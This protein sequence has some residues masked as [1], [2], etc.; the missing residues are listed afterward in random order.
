M[1]G[2]PCDGDM[3]AASEVE[4]Q[5]QRVLDSAVFV[6]APILSRFLRYVVEHSLADAGCGLK[7]YVLGVDVFGRGADFDNG[8]GCRDERMI[9]HKH[10]VTRPDA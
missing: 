5:L 3:P 8:F 4:A 7:E 6:N 1:N 9:R 2:F 10:F